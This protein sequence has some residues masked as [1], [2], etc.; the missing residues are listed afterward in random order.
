MKRKLILLVFVVLGIMAGCAGKIEE[1]YIDVNG[2]NLAYVQQGEG[3]PLI[4][5]HG[6]GGSCH[7]FD[8]IIDRLSKNYTV[9]AIDSRGQGKSSA[10]SEYN[11]QDMADDV[12]AFIKEKQ[13]ERPALYGFSDGGI[14][15]IILASQHPELLSALM[16]SGANLYPEGIKDEDRLAME[17]SYSVTGDPLLKMEITQP[18][19]TAEDLRKIKI[20]V[21]VTAGSDDMIKES[22]TRFIAENIALS[23]LNILEGESHTS[24]VLESTIIADLIEDFL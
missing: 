18:H 15:G 13:L 22:H 6:G 19:L 8:H 23:Q 2:V 21:L 5:L 12:E 20:P 10:A 16:V 3:K 24:Y 9:Y 4:L 11:Y 7:S 1:Q 17:K 14:T